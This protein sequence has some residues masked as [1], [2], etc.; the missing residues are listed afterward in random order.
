MFKAQTLN[1]V[2]QFDVYAER[3]CPQSLVSSVCIVR[4]KF[5]S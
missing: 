1:R 3:R 5:E 2:G 4:A